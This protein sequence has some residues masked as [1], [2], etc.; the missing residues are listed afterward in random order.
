MLKIRPNVQTGSSF[1]VLSLDLKNNQSKEYISCIHDHFD[2]SISPSHVVFTPPVKVSFL[3]YTNT[4]QAYCLLVQFNY[5][6]E[7]TSLKLKI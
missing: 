3:S 1:Q 5:T 2:T 4:R 7:Q 6:K